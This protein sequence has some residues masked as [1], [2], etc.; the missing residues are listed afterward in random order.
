MTRRKNKKTKATFGVTP[1]ELESAKRMIYSDSLPQRIRGVK[2]LGES[3]DPEASRLLLEKA[4]SDEDAVVRENSLW[5]Y[6]YH[7]AEKNFD[8]VMNH[9]ARAFASDYELKGLGMGAF[10]ASV[11]DLMNFDKPQASFHN[12]HFGKLIR[13]APDA[14]TRMMA[15][16]I[17]NY[18]NTDFHYIA[19]ALEDPDPKNRIRAIDILSIVNYRPALY[20]IIELSENDRDK[21]VVTAA[22]KAIKNMEED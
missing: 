9:V 20:K 5:W 1:K 4:F 16:E 22:K 15:L 2:L 12:D 3:F 18:L 13:E 8:E 10:W 17:L 6:A 11:V 21:K 19:Q 14:D 7:K